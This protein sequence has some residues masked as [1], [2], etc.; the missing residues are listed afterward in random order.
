M[1][2][3]AQENAQKSMSTLQELASRATNNM[4]Q[5]S[6]LPPGRLG[7]RQSGFGEERVLGSFWTPKSSSLTYRVKNRP[8]RGLRHAVP[9][10]SFPQ[11]QITTPRGPISALATAGTAARTPAAAA[12]ARNLGFLYFSKKY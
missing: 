5:K 6:R 7:P 9:S 10:T 2:A 12:G 3:A 8:S 4:K 11:R 1:G